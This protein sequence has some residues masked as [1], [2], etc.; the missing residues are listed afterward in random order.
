MEKRLLREVLSEVAQAKDLF[1]LFLSPG[2]S[3]RRVWQTLRVL[4]T[5]GDSRLFE[6]VARRHGL[7]PTYLLHRVQGLLRQLEDI[8]ANNPYALLGVEYT[9]PPS[10]VHRRWRDLMKEWHPDRKGE[11]PEAQE[12]SRRINEAYELLKDRDR[13]REYDKKHAPFLHILKEMGGEEPSLPAPSREAPFKWGTWGL[14]GGLLIVLALFF[15]FFMGKTPPPSTVKVALAPSPLS[16]RLGRGTA[17]SVGE[18]AQRKP[19]EG[20]TYSP[21]LGVQKGSTPARAVAK[22]PGKPLPSSPS[23]VQRKVLPSL[24]KAELHEKRETSTME[25]VVRTASLSHSKKRGVRDRGKTSRLGRTQKSGAPRAGLAK[26]TTKKPEK[27]KGTDLSLSASLAPCSRKESST[28]GVKE[29]STRRPETKGGM[30]LSKAP[31]PSFQKVEPKKGKVNPS[32]ERGNVSPPLQIVERFVEAY[33]KGDVLAFFSLFSRDA[34]EQGKPIKTYLP[35]YR[36][37]FRT[38][39]VVSYR[40][41]EKRVENQKGGVEV[42]GRYLLGLVPRSGG[43]LHWVRG[44]VS[45]L[46]APDERNQWLIKRLNYT[47]E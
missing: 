45:W 47:L 16:S 12:Y 6:K 26:R 41:M 1:Q 23:P 22:A 2:S 44:R 15:I 5:M 3:P 39:Q 7:D 30:E 4:E 14:A 24:A 29:G 43:T 11:D 28:P 10:E 37:F 33:C 35:R 9:A 25:D 38:F 40:I 34:M 21:S 42:K 36:Y 27:R 13:R 18:V 17:S 31:F 20:E 8:R 19:D 46:L 32:F